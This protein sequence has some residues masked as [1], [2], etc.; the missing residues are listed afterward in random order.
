MPYST[1]QWRI[2][3][4]VQLVP[5]GCLAVGIL[6]TKESPRWLASRGRLDEALRNLSNIRNLDPN[7]TYV[8]EE[9]Y[10]IKL[11]IEN[12]I[13]HAGTGVMAPMKTLLTSRTY[14]KRLGLCIML[15]AMQN[16]TGKLDLGARSPSALH[17]RPEVALE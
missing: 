11:A 1:R 6:L 13:A 4:G 2:P 15:F 12:D 17:T 8:Q 14:L 7:H 9:L 3:F 16:G 5:G 10:E